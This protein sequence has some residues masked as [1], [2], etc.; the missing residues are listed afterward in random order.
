VRER[1]KQ[2]ERVRVSRDRVSGYEREREIINRC[3]KR[4]RETE[5]ERESL[6]QTERQTDRQT[7]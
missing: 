2:M 3:R 1:K 7:G 5:V 6:T 4:C